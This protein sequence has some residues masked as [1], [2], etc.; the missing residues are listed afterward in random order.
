MAMMIVIILMY[1][2]EGNDYNNHKD[3][4]SNNIINAQN[5]TIDTDNVTAMYSVNAQY[6]TIHHDNVNT[7][8]SI[9]T[10]KK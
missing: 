2:D 5:K 3:N 1:I 6:K 4:V 10:K 9:I 7:I 8:P